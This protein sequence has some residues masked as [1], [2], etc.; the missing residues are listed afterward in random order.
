MTSLNK[1][2]GIINFSK[3]SLDLFANTMICYLNSLSDLN[4]SYAMDFRSQSFIPD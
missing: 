1:V 4:L 2:I 3:L